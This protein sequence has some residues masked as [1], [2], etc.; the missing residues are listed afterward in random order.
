MVRE[1]FQDIKSKNG[2]QFSIQFFIHAHIF[3]FMYILFCSAIF[4]D[5]AWLLYFDAINVIY[6]LYML[7]VICTHIGNP[8]DNPPPLAWLSIRG[9]SIHTRPNN[10]TCYQYHQKNYDSKRF[11]NSILSMDHTCRQKLLTPET[12]PDYYTLYGTDNSSTFR[13]P[14]QIVHKIKQHFTKK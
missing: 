1:E 3:V 12:K 6:L 9:H 8:A 11:P 2:I 13:R 10:S 14:Q 7:S 5:D 4:V